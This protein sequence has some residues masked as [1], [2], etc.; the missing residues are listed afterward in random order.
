MKSTHTAS[1][2]LD[3][4]M[5]LTDPALTASLTTYLHL[6]L[7]VP[8]D[9]DCIGRC[10]LILSRSFSAMKSA[11]PNEAIIPYD[12]QPERSNSRVH[13]YRNVRID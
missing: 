10:R 3:I 12:S 4:E 8:P 13:Y 6:A 5:N 11:D 9:R 2:V 7:D 1:S